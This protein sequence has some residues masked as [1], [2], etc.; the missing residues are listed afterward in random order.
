MNLVRAFFAGFLSTLIFH[1]GLLA[2]LHAAGATP[3][4]PYAM[5][6]TPPFGVPQ[7]LSLAFWG[8]VWGL[9]LW[10]AVRKL[11][12]GAYWLASIVFGA[13]LPSAVAFLV[14]FPLKGMSPPPGALPKMLLGAL[15]LNGAWGF[16]VA[17]GMRLLDGRAAKAAAA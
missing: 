1:Q 11:R 7:V 3:I 10:A 12:G 17:L 13:V 15:L 4:A 8:G 2:I 16:G 9:P 14:V 5:G 6:S